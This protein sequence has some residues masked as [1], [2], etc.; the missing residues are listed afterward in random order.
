MGE[1]VNYAIR[2]ADKDP[3]TG[4]VIVSACS[5][6]LNNMVE[7]CQNLTFYFFRKGPRSVIL[8]RA[9]NMWLDR[10]VVP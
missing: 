2:N 6:P 8:A 9:L 5:Y 4:F 3:S 10:M 1:F 7:D